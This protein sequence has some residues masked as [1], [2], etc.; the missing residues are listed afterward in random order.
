MYPTLLYAEVKCNTCVKESFVLGWEY[1]P[2]RSRYAALVSKRRGTG[3]RLS[4][5][6][7]GQ[8]GNMSNR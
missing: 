2:E 1:Q 3:A 8:C 5:Y 6:R 7:T 4:R